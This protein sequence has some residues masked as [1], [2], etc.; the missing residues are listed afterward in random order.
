MCKIDNLIINDLMIYNLLLEKN[1]NITKL[2]IC[3]S[4]VKQVIILQIIYKIDLIELKKNIKESLNINL[5]IKNNEKIILYIK[6]DELKRFPDNI[7][8]FSICYNYLNNNNKFINSYIRN[9]FNPNKSNPI[10]LTQSRL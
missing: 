7:Y 2:L 5:R 6:F 10:H 8:E 3:D 4:N 9:K 1:Y